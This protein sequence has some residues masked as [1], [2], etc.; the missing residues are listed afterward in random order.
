V[1]LLQAIQLAARTAKNIPK[2]F[3]QA[4]KHPDYYTHWL[5]A[6]E[7]QLQQLND[8]KTWD[9]VDRPDHA[10][11]LPGKWVYDE[12][13]TTTNGIF[14]RA[15]WV[16][17]GNFAE[18]GG[19]GNAYAAVASSTTV[20]VCLV[21]TTVRG[22]LLWAFDINTAFLNALMPEGVV[23]YVEQP[24]GVSN[25]T[26]VCRLNRAL[27]G[28]KEAPLYWFLTICPVMKK[29]GFEPFD[30][31]LCLFYTKKLVQADEGERS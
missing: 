5:P 23:V 22:F 11:V 14:E 4:R 2:N 16:V 27:Y 28:L 19:W 12:K 30:S 25:G 15:R 18:D 7:R 9:L 24:H 21:I 31:D 13:L 10:K 6:M 3:R 1:S 26:K 17:C 29:L 8:I 20:R